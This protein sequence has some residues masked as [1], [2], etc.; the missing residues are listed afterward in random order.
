MDWWGGGVPKRGVW[1]SSS[2]KPIIPLLLISQQK[3]LKSPLLEIRLLETIE[4]A[5]PEV[6]EKVSRSQFVSTKVV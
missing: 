1:R 2:P 5:V 4:T 3:K 6:E